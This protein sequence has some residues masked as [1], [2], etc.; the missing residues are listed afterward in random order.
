[1]K[2]YKRFTEWSESHGLYITGIDGKKN[3]VPDCRTLI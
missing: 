3:D 1:M 2:D